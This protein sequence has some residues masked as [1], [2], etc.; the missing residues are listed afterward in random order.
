KTVNAGCRNRKCEEMFTVVAAES[1][2]PLRWLIRNDL[3]VA[4]GAAFGLQRVG[5]G[6][7]RALIMASFVPSPPRFAARPAQSLARAVRQRPSRGSPRCPPPRR[8]DRR[9][10]VC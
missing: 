7:H 3:R 1:Q 10:P 2:F 6:H 8:A 4:V 5:I 9:G